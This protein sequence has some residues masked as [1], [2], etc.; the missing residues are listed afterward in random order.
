MKNI[1][2]ALVFLITAS[3]FAQQVDL[4][5]QVLDSEFNN[6]PLAFAN[7]KV[8]GLDLGAVSDENGYY[9]LALTPGSYT[10]EVEFIGYESQV[11]SEVIVEAADLEL[12]PVVLGARRMKKDINVALSEDQVEPSNE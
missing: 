10:L 7:V 3:A 5:G 11:I 8:K 12:D 1:I 6:E 4:K 9:S 2:T